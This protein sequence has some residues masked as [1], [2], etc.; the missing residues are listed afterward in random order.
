MMA[1]G[2][3]ENYIFPP[4]MIWISPTF[5]AVQPFTHAEIEQAVMFQMNAHKAPGPFGIYIASI[6][7]IGILGPE[8][9]LI[10]TQSSPIILN[11][12]YLLKVLIKLNWIKAVRFY[13]RPLFYYSGENAVTKYMLGI[14]QHTEFVVSPRQ[15]FCDPLGSIKKKGQHRLPMAVAYGRYISILSNDV[16]FRFW[17]PYLDLLFSEASTM[18]GVRTVIYKKMLYLLIKQ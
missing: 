13:I 12:A 1:T 6:C 16:H 17:F 7:S 15:K 4:C 2:L 10:S 14:E 18:L 5:G 11:I 9:T 8:N 3:Q